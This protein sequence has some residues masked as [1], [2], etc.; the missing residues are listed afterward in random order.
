MTLKKSGF[1]LRATDQDIC[2]I[3]FQDPP[4][5]I[6]DGWVEFDNGSF[7][8]DGHKNVVTI[9]VLELEELM[10]NINQWGL[11]E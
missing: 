3:T 1:V 9:S 4:G 10:R 11:D 2:V 6:G 7:D 8:S 5:N